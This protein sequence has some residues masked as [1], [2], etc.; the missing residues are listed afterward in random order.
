[1]TEDVFSFAIPR[2]KLAY[3]A[4]DRE[5]LAPRLGPATHLHIVQR[6]VV[7]S[8]LEDPRAEPEPPIGP[9]ECFP[10]GAL[11]A[12]GPPTKVYHALADTF[13]YQ[14]PRDDFLELRRRSPEFERFCTRAITE[15][16]QQSLAQ[17]SAHYVQRAAEQQSIARP[18]SGLVRREPVTCAGDAPLSDALTKMSDARVRTVVVV[19]RDNEPIGMFTLVDLL[20]R[21]V[22]PS[23]PL[24]T[25]LAE[26]MSAPVVTLPAGAT[27][28]QAMETMAAREVRQIVVVEGA[29]LVGV[30]NERD[31]FTLTRV[32]MR[33]VL[34]GLRE[35]PSIGALRYCADDIRGL[36]HT[37]LA[38]G[39]T[40]EP[41]IRTIA[42]LNDAL[43]RRA[44]EQML[45]RHE[46]DGTDW[47]WLALGSEGRSEQTFASDQD[48]AL[49]F[50]VEAGVDAW[51]TRLL[52]FAHDVNQAFATLGF[53][54]CEGG[55]MARNPEYC[56]TVTEWKDR[57]MGWLTAPTPHALLGANIAFDFRPLFG[58]TTLADDLRSW[59]FGY[60]R[61]NK[62]F[63]RL[64]AQN[65]LESGAPLGLIRTFATD[66]D[67]VHRG[68]LDIK[69]RGTRLFVDAARVFALAFAIHETN[70]VSRLRAA[71]RA[72]RVEA[73]H[74]EATVEAFHFLQLL[75]LRLQDETAEPGS[76]NR[77]DP[78][79][80]NEVDQ[81]MLKEAFRQARKL[82]DL[83]ARTYDL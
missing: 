35:A 3:F 53:P 9:G 45:A 42:A 80:L 37:L 27:A 39:V 64:M 58:A 6:G 54:L 30:V 19:G 2:M 78:D 36:A 72:L 67:A 51:R 77:L 8:R 57:F 16:L 29:R 7:G 68:T 63:L 10:V 24:T 22:L 50:A 79:M 65:A 21:V 76:R 17:L 13:C 70:T 82:Q 55:V 59:V 66:D 33:Q 4:K 38:Q 75:R 14:L 15:T 71:G 11:S 49:V 18:L 74:V 32:S 26:V 5:I 52:A 43:A 25:P 48:N 28:H 73:R 81:R 23:K 60:S 44:I 20:R 31:L 41:L 40:A 83:L 1:M 69:T 61:E 12:G 46:L 56:M 62:V 47:C 34:D